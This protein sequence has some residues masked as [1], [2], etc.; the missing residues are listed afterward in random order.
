MGHTH[1][2]KRSFVDTLV[3]N[4]K[5]KKSR[6]KIFIKR[7]VKTIPG[8]EF[9]FFPNIFY[10]QKYLLFNANLLHKTIFFICLSLELLSVSCKIYEKN[11]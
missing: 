3:A 10:A 7:E 4:K 2:I 1:S 8:I 9:I 11:L 6:T 5:Q